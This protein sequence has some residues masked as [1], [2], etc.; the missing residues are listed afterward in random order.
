MNNSLSSSFK[1][2]KVL[3]TLLDALDCNTSRNVT[4]PCCLMIN[5]QA[6]DQI[7]GHKMLGPCL[8]NSFTLNLILLM[9]VIFVMTWAE[10]LYGNPY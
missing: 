4:T 5:I 1:L 3:K 7:C 8:S 2:S 10:C 9:H 6:F